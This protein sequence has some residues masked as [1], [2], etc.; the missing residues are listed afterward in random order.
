MKDSHNKQTDSD[1]SIEIIKNQETKIS[2]LKQELEG[3][4]KNKESDREQTV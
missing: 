1:S 4:L 3:N 2:D